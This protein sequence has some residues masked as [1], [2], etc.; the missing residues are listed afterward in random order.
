[1]TLIRRGLFKVCAAVTMAM[2][3]VL[4]PSWRRYGHLT[5]DEAERRGFLPA[6]VLLNGRD[7]SK[8]CR[9]CD[10]VQGRV[11]LM[12]TDASGKHYVCRDGD[13]EVEQHYGRVEFYP[14]GTY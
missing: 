6:R 12:A 9:E 13:V 7:V 10:D 1:M 4:P 2:P 11:L 8:D 14:K 3:F 5:V